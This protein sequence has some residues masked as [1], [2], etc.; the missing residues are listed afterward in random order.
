MRQKLILALCLFA[1][2]HVVLAEAPERLLSPASQIYLRWDGVDTHQAGYAKTAVGKVFAGDAGRLLSEILKPYQ[3]Q[4]LYQLLDDVGQ[5]GAILGVE[6]RQLDQ[7]VAQLTVVF[8][9]AKMRAK[10]IN[11]GLRW[12]IEASGERVRE[13]KVMGRSVQQSA[14]ASLAWWVE[15]DDLVLITGP[16]GPEE[17]LKRF[18]SQKEGLTSQPL[19]KK[20]TAFKDFETSIRGF[21]DVAAVL[22]LLPK[23]NG[24][25]AKV[26]EKLGLRGIRSVTL[27]HGFD[28]QAVRSLIAVNMPGP[29]QGLARLAGA[30]PFSLDDLP[31]LPQDLSGFTALR[32]D[33][34]ALYDGTIELLDGF[35]PPPQARELKSGIAALNQA[36]G[37]DLRQDLLGAL[38]SLVVT[39][40]A[41]GEGMMFMGQTLLIEV[42]D[43]DKLRAALAKAVSGLQ[44]MVGKR[45]SVTQRDYHGTRLHML[46]VRQQGFIFV[47]SYALHKKWLVVGLYPQPVEG[48]ILRQLG[49][50]PSWK[51]GPVVQV[52]LQHLPKKFT[53]FAWADPRPTIKFLLSWTPMIVAG[54]LSQQ[55]DLDFDLSTVPNAYSITRHL[56]PSVTVADDD[57]TTLRLQSMSSLPL[58]PGFEGIDTNA[59]VVSLAAIS[60]IGQNAQSTFKE[61]GEKL[62]APPPKPRR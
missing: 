15:G 42:K 4:Q 51:P 30:E 10:S 26:I 41:P 62:E 47:P 37:I 13:A 53:Y 58:P 20:A 52:H 9:E 6:L 48:F 34:A 61:V 32:L 5:R 19:L 59:V 43:A 35:L 14:P 2:P 23:E 21:V 7:P 60:L 56:F 27:Q 55:P 38:G 12:L 31:P 39:Y 46:R 11:A 45:F 24:E 40:A 16:D 49:E 1:V 17:V 44:A 22:A 36:L 18:D 8:P 29:R 3:G 28:G 57:G 33:L 54:V 50:L 25:A